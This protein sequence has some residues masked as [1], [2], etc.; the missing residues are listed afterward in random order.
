MTENGAR[1]YLVPN[2]RST[3]TTYRHGNVAGGTHLY[4]VSAI[5]WT[6]VGPPSNVIEI[7]LEDVLSMRQWLGSILSLRR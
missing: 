5:T 1:I 4:A 7:K 6:G 3:E 2:T